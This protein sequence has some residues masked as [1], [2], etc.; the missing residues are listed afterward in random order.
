MKG[1]KKFGGNPNSCNVLFLQGFLKR[2]TTKISQTFSRTFSGTFSG[3]LL[4][5]TWLCT[6]A[7]QT[8]TGTFS[9]TLWNLTSFCTKANP[10]R[11]PVEPDLSGS[12]PKPFRRSQELSPEPSWTLLGFAPRLLGT[13][14][15]PSL[16]HSLPDFPRNWNPVEPDLAPHQCLPNLSKTFSKPRCNWPGS[17][18]KPPTLSP[19]PLYLDEIDAPDFD[20]GLCTKTWGNG[21]E[22]I[23]ETPGGH[24]LSL[25]GGGDHNGVGICMLRSLL[26]YASQ[27]SFH[28]V[29]A[30]IRQ[31]GLKRIEAN[32]RFLKLLPFFSAFLCR[33][34]SSSLC[35][36]F[37]TG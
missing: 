19:E 20:I 37:Y 14:A 34:K 29:G 31:Y 36:L 22:K 10:L 5:L 1:G 26:S 17:A 16:H 25:T 27:I 3:T 28:A 23:A 7:S 18:P 32:H 15:E 21:E 11:N 8:F 13:F 30:R 9:G 6:K 2:A 24:R 4:P 33:L 35:W 12:A